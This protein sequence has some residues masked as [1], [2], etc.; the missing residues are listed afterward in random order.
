V[1]RST[2]ILGFVALLLLLVIGGG[3]SALM[4]RSA[5]PGEVTG[6]T[7]TGVDEV[8][9][10]TVYAPTPDQTTV[11]VVQTAESMPAFQTF[12]AL[13]DRCIA[14]DDLSCSAVQATVQASSVR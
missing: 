8:L 6:E 12:V 9:T 2:L 13:E 7:I 11:R 14:G 3:V 10:S 4:Q 1:K 5:G